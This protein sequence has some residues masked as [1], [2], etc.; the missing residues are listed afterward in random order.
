VKEKAMKKK[1]KRGRIDGDVPTHV[2]VLGGRVQIGNGNG[3]GVSVRAMSEEGRAYY[4]SLR[5]HVAWL[6]YFRAA[7]DGA[8][9]REGMSKAQMVQ[10]AA[11]V[12]DLAQAEEL[13]R[14]PADL[15]KSMKRRE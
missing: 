7:L 1:M 15:R 2:R 14:R 12:A 5:N 13:R 10:A 6:R 3:Q 4:R 9:K 8:L 11:H